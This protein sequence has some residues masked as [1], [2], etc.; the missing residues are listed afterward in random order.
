MTALTDDTARDLLR[1]AG[2][3]IDVDAA[4]P[5]DTS[6][7][8][9][10]RWPVLAAAAAVVLIVSGAALVVPGNSRPDPEPGSTYLGAGTDDPAFHLGPDQVPSIFGH[11]TEPAR[12]LL[13]ERGLVVTVEPDFSCDPEGYAVRTAPATGALVQPGDA[14][15]LFE[16]RHPPAAFCFIDRDLYNGYALLSYALGEGPAPHT[17]GTVD[18]QPALRLLREWSARVGRSDGPRRFTFPTPQLTVFDGH[19]GMAGPT[20]AVGRGRWRTFQVDWAWSPAYVGVT[21]PIRVLAVHYAGGPGSATID[22][23]AMPSIV[24]PAPTGP[25]DVVGNSRA[26]ATARLTAQ[27]YDVEA[28]PRRDCQPVGI[29]S[30]QRPS[31]NEGVEPGATVT[32]VYTDASGD[33][34]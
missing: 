29:V 22:A 3:T 31:A 32:I 33:C 23:I 30:T 13:E 26:V 24:S 9:R 21:L 1:R 12:A 2:D 18:L 28:V 4:G 14:V 5:L 15:T 10:R 7:A 17:V 19:Q 6:L 34:A 25:P 27:G 8:P 20:Q 16:S 11:R